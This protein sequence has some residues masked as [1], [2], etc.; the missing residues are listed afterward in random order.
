MKKNGGPKSR[1]TVPLTTSYIYLHEAVNCLPVFAQTL[2]VSAEEIR[3]SVQKQ[4]YFMRE[5]KDY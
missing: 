4:L 1:W 2:A 3:M 5:K